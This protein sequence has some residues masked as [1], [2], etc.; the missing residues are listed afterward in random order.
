MGVAAAVLIGVVVA[1]GNLP[2]PIEHITQLGRTPSASP[3]ATHGGNLQEAGATPTKPAATHDPAPA[4]GQAA[5]SPAP[6]PVP[7]SRLCQEFYGYFTH[8]ESRASWPAEVSLYQQLRDLAGGPDLISYCRPYVGKMFHDEDPGTGPQGS[9]DGGS[10]GLQG[11][12]GQGKAPANAAQAS[13][14]PAA[15]SAP[16]R[17]GG[18]GS[19]PA[20]GNT[21]PGQGSQGSQGSQGGGP[22]SN[23]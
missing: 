15:S 18:A 8:P 12:H 9:R 19:S 5:A 11:S 20:N 22:P 3:S 14:S 17:Q 21:G 16:A 23:R 7:P 2:G 4:R 1:S 6:S 13:P 10:R